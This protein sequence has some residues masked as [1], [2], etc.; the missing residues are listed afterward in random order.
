MAHRA[1]PRF[2]VTK[3]RKEIWKN[4]HEHSPCHMDT[5]TYY[6]PVEGGQHAATHASIAGDVLLNGH[7]T[8]AVPMSWLQCQVARSARFTA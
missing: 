1:S 4:V 6:L 5:F 8:I 2:V 3:E 7:M